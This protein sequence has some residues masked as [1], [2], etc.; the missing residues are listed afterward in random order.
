MSSGRLHDALPINVDVAAV[1]A[2]RR[3]FPD[4]EVE[5]ER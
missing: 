1:I 2:D 3:T 5:A 4:D